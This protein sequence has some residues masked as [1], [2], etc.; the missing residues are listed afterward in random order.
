M[1]TFTFTKREYSE[2]LEIRSK[3]D[4]LLR[5]RRRIE[6]IKRDGLSR[7]FGIL[8]DSFK[9]DSLDYV[10]KLRKEWRK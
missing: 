1:E 8:K 5:A 4:K 3:L 2:L 9:E 7:A 6:F 10:S